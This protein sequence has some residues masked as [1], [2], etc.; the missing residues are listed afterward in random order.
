MR[1][2][3]LALVLVTGVLAGPA[4]AS[5][6]MAMGDGP[7][8]SIGF[9]AFAPTQRTALEGDTVTWMNESVRVHTVTATDGSFASGGVAGGGK[10]AHRFT[11]P[12]RFAYYCSLHPSMRGEIDVE[13][14]LLDAPTQPAGRNRPYP[15]AGRAAL[16]AGSTVTIEGDDGSGFRPAGT[17]TVDDGGAFHLTVTPRATTTYRAVAGADVAPAIRVLVLDRKVRAS[18]RRHGTRVRFS[19]IVAPG[20]PGATV[21]LQLHL[22]DRFGWWPV[23]RA[24]LDGASRARFAL[25]LRHATRARVVLTLRDGYTPLAVSP[26]LKVARL[27]R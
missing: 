7:M 17:A 11:A 2:A 10:Y 23:A 8:V 3:A 1:R 25:T 9:A 5:G 24:R 4:A 27:A 22:R 18:A 21:V 12:G 6:D 13:T 16:P 15:L 26:T 14:L 20:S 19:A